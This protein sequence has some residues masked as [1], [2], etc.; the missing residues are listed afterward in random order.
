MVSRIQDE[1][2]IKRA[3]IDKSRGVLEG[4]FKEQLVPFLPKFSY[5]PGDARFIGSPV[6]LIIF[7]GASNKKIDKIVFL[8]IKSGKNELTEKEKDI[9]KCITDG[10]VEFKELR[11]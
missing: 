1:K 4:K 6:D 5:N 2:A 11:V 8:E 10:K 9:R 7:N 3:A